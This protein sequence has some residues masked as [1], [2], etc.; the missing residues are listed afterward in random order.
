MSKKL[1]CN[2]PDN[3]LPG[4]QF[5]DAASSIVERHLNDDYDPLN[6]PYLD[7][8]ERKRMAKKLRRQLRNEKKQKKKNKHFET[9]NNNNN[10][11]YNRKPVPK[12]LPRSARQKEY[13]D[14]LN[15]P[16]V[17]ILFGVGPAGTGKTYIAT[18]WAAIA[19]QNDIF[20]KIII[21]RPTV[22]VSEKIGYLPGTLEEKMEPWLM[23]IIDV[24]EEVLG[25]PK[26]ETF[27]RLGK[28]EIAPLAF[29]RGRTF[30]NA[31][32]LLDEAQN[33]TSDQ[34]K[35]FLTRIGE[36]SKMVITGDMKQSDFQKNNG[37]SDFIKRFTAT[38]GI[39]LIEFDKSDIQRHHL[40]EHILKMYGDED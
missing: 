10:N 37:L 24:L 22:S 29:M 15:D 9:Q 26:V 11:N 21:T 6:D 23:P 7:D 40:I 4:N 5:S 3:V 32:V 18:M 8:R 16:Y 20:D 28:I 27:I 35:M 30:K 1:V 2:L 34:F 38:D 31:I 33:C 19:L 17:H 25:K 39:E 36:G 14:Y 12:L 13:I